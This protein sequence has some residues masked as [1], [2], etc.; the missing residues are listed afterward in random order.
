MCFLNGKM[1]W[2]KLNFRRESE[3]VKPRMTVY[4]PNDDFSGFILIYSLLDS[5][6]FPYSIYYKPLMRWTLEFLN[7]IFNDMISKNIVNILFH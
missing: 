2:V 5:Q 4:S 1:K 3:F 6:T 7:S